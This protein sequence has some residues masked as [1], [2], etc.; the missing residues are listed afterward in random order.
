[1]TAPFGLTTLLCSVDRSGAGR[2]GHRRR[3]AHGIG[4]RRDR[5]VVGS[6]GL[7]RGRRSGVPRILPPAAGLVPG[8]L[9]PPRL[10]R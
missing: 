4:D 7:R 10:Q 1:M 5:H 9:Q 6:R 3:E 2:E 8:L